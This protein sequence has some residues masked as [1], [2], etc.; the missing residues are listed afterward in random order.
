[1]AF[2]SLPA[3]HLPLVT[4]PMPIAGISPSG[5]LLWPYRSLH[6]RQSSYYDSTR[7]G[8][9]LAVKKE[10]GVGPHRPSE[11]NV[12][13]TDYLEFALSLQQ[14]VRDPRSS[15]VRAERHPTARPRIG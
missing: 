13:D 1:M 6:R 15:V 3:I 14:R 10:M 4:S 12:C 9:I 8:R 7:H 5:T 11:R 2:L